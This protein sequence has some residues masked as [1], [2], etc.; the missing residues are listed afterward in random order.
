MTKLKHDLH[1]PALQVI[2]ASI[3][4]LMQKLNEQKVSHYAKNQGKSSL[5]RG[6]MA[7]DLPVDRL[8]EIFKA[9]NEGNII[10]A[11]LPFY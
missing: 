1:P 2:S 10:I 4:L 5:N 7:K 11:F 8:T 9:I 6:T 3:L